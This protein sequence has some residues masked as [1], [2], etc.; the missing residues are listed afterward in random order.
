MDLCSRVHSMYNM[1]T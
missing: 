1:I